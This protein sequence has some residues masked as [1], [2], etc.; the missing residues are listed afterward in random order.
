MP[1]VERQSPR[2]TARKRESGG[3]LKYQTTE[4]KS[5][6]HVFLRNTFILTTGY[7]D[8]ADVNVAGRKRRGGTCARAHADAPQPLKSR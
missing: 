1:T 8:N 4:R 6:F 2:A 3:S 5:D 7:T